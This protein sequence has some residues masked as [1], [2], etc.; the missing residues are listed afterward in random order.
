MR[1]RT[2][3]RL[4]PR[5]RR[6]PHLISKNARHR[7]VPPPRVRRARPPGDEMHAYDSK[8]LERL[9]GLPPSAVRAL[10][11]A[12]NINPVRRKGKLHYTFQDL[13]VLRTASALRA[14]KIPSQ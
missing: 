2:P 3:V 8:D 5:R 13:V 14:A 6:W 4:R 12:G 1:A 7:S 11:R 9:F 10:A